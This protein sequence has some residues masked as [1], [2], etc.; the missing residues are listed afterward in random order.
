MQVIRVQKLT[1]LATAYA[2]SWDRLAGSSPFTSWTWMSTWWKYYGQDNELYVLVVKDDAGEVLGI[3]PW[4]QESS[5]T[6]GRRIKFLGMGHACS[7]YLGL[8]AKDEDLSRVCR[9]IAEWLHFVNDDVEQKKLHGWDFLSVEGVCPTDTSM[10]CL[11]EALDALGYQINF[12]STPSCWRNELRGNWDAY[13]AGLSKKRRRKVRDLKRKYIDTGRTTF[14]YAQTAEQMRQF[15]QDFVELHCSRRMSL[16]DGGCF[17]STEFSGFLREVTGHCF[18]AGN[19]LLARLLLDGKLASCSV[20]ILRD[21]THFMYQTGMQPKL[22]MHNPGWLMNI[23]NIL[24]GHQNGVEVIDYLRGDEPYKAKLGA[25]EVKAL[26]F[27]VVALQAGAKVR[28][29]VWQLRATLK[30]NALPVLGL[31]GGTP[32]EESASP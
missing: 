6:R 1:E 17:V 31:L 2:E 14:E 3:A 19:L 12:E 9:A 27:R 23:H 21:K 11:R 10:A 32:G 25:E 13:L 24:E 16:G 7:D 5:T 29:A 8:L 22:H 18:Q 15:Y 26:K 20:G 28:G 4:Y 30:Q